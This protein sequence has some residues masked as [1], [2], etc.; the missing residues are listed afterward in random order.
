MVRQS[1]F[2][3]SWYP[4]DPASLGNLIGGVKES[5]EG[6]TA[7][8]AVV[9]HAGL[10]YSAIGIAP[11]FEN[12]DR[13]VARLLV[14]GPSHY[15]H[16]PA[17]RLVVGPFDSYETPLGSLEGFTLDGA[18]ASDASL[19]QR[20]HSVEMVL[21]FIAGLK[22]PPKVGTALVNHFSSLK[23]LDEMSDFLLEEDEGLSIVASSD[24]THYGPRFG[25]SVLSEQEARERDM[26]VA[27]LLASGAIEEAFSFF[28]GNRHTIC[29]WASAALVANIARRKGM[30][31]EVAGYYTSND[32]SGR[33]DGDFVAYA[34]ILWRHDGRIS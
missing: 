31:G 11:F 20:E 29:G 4:A 9:P 18:K 14:I 22:R 34:T 8:F 7:R 2:A 23:A 10:S 30:K 12:F 1:F 3:G 13:S 21:P 15:A 19:L 24:F 17:D 26:H 27:H 16:I 5:R 25:F 32:V 28:T 33:D 6:A